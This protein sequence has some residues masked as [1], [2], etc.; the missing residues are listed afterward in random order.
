MISIKDFHPGQTVYY[1]RGT[2]QIRIFGQHEK[3]PLEKGVVEAVGRK[4]VTAKC[5]YFSLK[6]CLPGKDMGDGSCLVGEGGTRL[7][8]S[9][10]AFEDWFECVELRDWFFKNVLYEIGDNLTLPQLRTIKCFHE[11]NMKSNVVKSE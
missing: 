6:F 9:E 1:W 8:I 2:N 3:Q 4:Y 7:F 11:E 10:K 5:G